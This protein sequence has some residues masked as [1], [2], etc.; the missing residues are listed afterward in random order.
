MDGASPIDPARSCFGKTRYG[1]QQTA[2]DVAAKCYAERRVV[3]RVYAC[4]AGCG[5]FHLTKTN[6][7]EAAQRPGW[8]PPEKSQRQ[9]AREQRGR[10]RR[11]RGRR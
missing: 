8:R 9:K 11:R 5:G 6:A 2:N 3:L 4:D 10:E 7:L 1:D